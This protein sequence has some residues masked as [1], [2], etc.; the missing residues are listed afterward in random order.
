MDAQKE[1]WGA[2]RRCMLEG[3]IDTCFCWLCE[4]WGSRGGRGWRRSEVEGLK[5]VV[6]VCV[7]EG[8]V[9]FCS[10]CDKFAV[11]KEKRTHARTVWV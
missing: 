7:V 1:E 8:S 10:L 4:V 2:G 3:D 6:G 11:Y 9:C 5:G